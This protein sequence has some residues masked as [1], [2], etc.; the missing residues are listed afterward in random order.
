MPVCIGPLKI[1]LIGP[2]VETS[3]D[4]PIGATLRSAVVLGVGGGAV[5]S[6]PPHAVP[7]SAPITVQPSRIRRFI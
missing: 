2:V 6:A 7:R 4:P 1:R 3:V 5:A